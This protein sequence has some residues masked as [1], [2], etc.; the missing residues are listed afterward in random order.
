MAREYTNRSCQL[1]GS[2]YCAMLNMESCRSCTVDCSTEL[3]AASVRADLDVIRSNMPEEGVHGLFAGDECLLCKGEP[4]KKKWYALTDL[5]HAE[6]RRRRSTMLGIAK[7]PRAGT[8]LPIQISC[9][10]ECRKRFLMLEY[11]SPVTGTFFA[12]LALTLL[13]FRPIR[14][15]IAAVSEILPFFVF[16]AATGIGI[17]AGRLIRRLLANK[18]GAL[19]HTDVMELPILSAMAKKGWFELNPNKDTSRLVFSRVPIRQGLFTAAPETEGTEAEK[20][21]ESMEKS[22]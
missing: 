4:L 10:E 12:A 8:V 14:E 16:L 6:P 1:Y 5:A 13:S 21:A 15:P 11:A 2:A 3:K 9:C 17:L 19:M 20:M 18:Y 7:E 22:E